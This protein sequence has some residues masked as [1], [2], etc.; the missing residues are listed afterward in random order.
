MGL[1]KNY[2]FILAGT[3]LLIVLIILRNSG[4]GHF[5][6]DAM[7]LAEP[8]FS[9]MN[10]IDAE[11]MASLT[12]KELLVCLTPEQNIVPEFK[13]TTLS[14]PYDSVLTKKYRN[15]LGNNNG[16]VIL[17]SP[18]ISV[19]ARVWMVLSQSGFRDVFI[20]DPAG[21]EVPVNK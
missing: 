11:G 8:S 3:L 5:R 1:I 18:D 14:I 13:G 15:L 2:K 12:G 9:G 16:S 4:T 6:Y 19:S 17:Y 10:I 21:D 7:K 20:L